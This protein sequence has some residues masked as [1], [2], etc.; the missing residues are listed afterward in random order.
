[1]ASRLTVVGPTY[2]NLGKEVGKWRS[3]TF[4]LHCRPYR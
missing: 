2:E 4:L 3:P 1:M